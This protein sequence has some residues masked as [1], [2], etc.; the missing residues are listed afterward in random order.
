MRVQ[1]VDTTISLPTYLIGPE[2]PNPPFQREGIWALYPYTMLDD[3][4][5]GREERTWRAIVLENDHVRV[6]VLPELGGRIHSVYD[7]HAEAEVFYCNR[8]VKPG[9][10]ATRGAWLAGGIEW[11]YPAGHHCNTASPVGCQVEETDDGATCW[12][13]ALDHRTRAKWVVGIRLARGS[14]RVETTV[15]VL[16]RTA[17]PGRLYFWENSAVRATDDLQ[18]VYPARRVLTC[19]GV[20]AYPITEDGRDISRY[21]AHPLWDDIFCLGTTD[22][23]FGSYSASEDLGVIH[24]AHPREALGKK[25]FTWG[26][27]PSGLV[28]A[29]ILSDED[30]PY[31]EIQ[32]GRFQTQGVWESLPACHAESW[33]EHWWPVHSIG[34]FHWAGYDAAVRLEPREGVA[35][36]GVCVSRTLTAPSVQLLAGGERIWHWSGT[37]SPGEPL[38]AEVAYS[39]PAEALRIEVFEDATLVL[40]YTHGHEPRVNEAAADQLVA[41][42]SPPA[43]GTP[44]GLLLAAAAHARTG[45]HEGARERYARAVE[46]DPSLV[47]AHAGLAVAALR[48]GLPAEAAEHAAAALALDA[49]CLSARYHL[50]LA[51]RALGEQA[52]AEDHLWLTMRAPDYEAPASVALA[53]LAVSAGRLTEGAELFERAARLEP[54]NS[55]VLVLLAATRRRLGDGVGA[56][57]ALR[58]AERAD[59]TDSLAA[60]EAWLAEPS[61]THAARVV[62]CT[63]G[64]PQD[65][66]ECAWDYHA[67]GLVE[68]ALRVLDLGIEHGPGAP[69]PLCVPHE[70]CPHPMLRYTRAWLLAALGREGEGREEQARGAALPPGGVF[71][72]RV[73]ELEVLAWAV[74]VDPAD[75]HAA[76]YLGNLLYSLARR[77]EAVARW[78]AALERDPSLAIAHRNLGLEA[79][80]RGETAEAERH[81]ADAI[82]ANPADYRYH[83]EHDEMLRLRRAAVATRLTALEAA[84]PEV[85]ARQDIAWRLAALRTAAGRHDEAIE[86]L[87]RHEFRPWEGAVQMRRVYVDALL[88]RGRARL[89]LGDAEGAAAD[90]EA[91]LEYP[92]NIGVGRLPEP[93]E[94][95]ELYWAARAR[96]EAGDAEGGRALVERALRESHGRASEGRAYQTRVRLLLAGRGEGSRTEADEAGRALL[97]ACAEAAEGSEDARAWLAL[98]LARQIRGQRAP[99]E[100]ALHKAL[101][102]D[103]ALVEA[104]LALADG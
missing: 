92:A 9:L 58:A 21:T 103:P 2:D 52:K 69:E 73:E 51:L 23:F 42:L 72:H 35:R 5:Q 11:N 34:G 57:D 87:A 98:G 86:T 22:E 4:G 24:V 75:A 62:A 78:A 14:A 16:N 77:E 36:I 84:P 12:V 50:G 89:S 37:L 49:H 56:R 61:V 91:A 25:F 40:G 74:A 54:A 79:A 63:R 97:T 30:G 88:A 104:G 76:L 81:Y 39:G 17:L 68:E 82:A 31:C 83:R 59:P 13:G 64:L 38:T 80:R 55:R 70:Q 100:A 48:R 29:E 43:E 96:L 93:G 44:H 18:L 46:A 99:A 6:T 47:E 32:G 41:S 33:H 66:L 95:R 60:V 90:F 101:A 1:L 71:P 94:A 45:D 53:E 3:V 27:A 15:R 85:R 10:V 20:A 19:G 65:Y 28:W 102:L 7:K 8:V 26:T 67:A